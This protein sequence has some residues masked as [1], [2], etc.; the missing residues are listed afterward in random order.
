MH[1]VTVAAPRTRGHTIHWA[2][3]YDVMFALLTGGRER[4]LRARIVALADLSPGARV[5][6]VGCGTGGLAIAAAERVRPTGTVH[7]VDASPAMVARARHRAARAGVAVTVEV[8]PVEALP[9]PAGAFD[10]VLSSLMLHHLPEDL[11]A[12]AFAEIR[13]VL[14][15]GGRLLAVDFEPPRSRTAR[16]VIRLVLTKRMADYDVRTCLPLMRDAGFV[17]VESGPTPYGWL[18][19]VRGR[20]RDRDD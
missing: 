18:T 3:L 10:A 1:H 12:Q 7:A 19:A 14:R 13:R 4:T 20:I 6:D 2:T 5:L 8:A 16:A 15:A 9:F 17:D 11:R